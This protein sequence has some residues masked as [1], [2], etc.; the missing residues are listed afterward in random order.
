M[1][2]SKTYCNFILTIKSK[3]EN[4]KT[5]LIKLQ[6]GQAV[7]LSVKPILNLLPSAIIVNEIKLG[8]DQF[9]KLDNS[10]LQLFTLAGVDL[11]KTESDSKSDNSNPFVDPKNDPEIQKLKASTVV[12]EEDI[13]IPPELNF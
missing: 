4:F 8:I 10:L 3:L 7:A 2:N 9:I 5:F 6:V 11:C 1:I 12:D 13:P